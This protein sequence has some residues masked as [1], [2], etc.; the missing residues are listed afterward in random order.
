M[1]AVNMILLVVAGIL[2]FGF[3]AEFIFKKFGI[4]DLLL[5][6]ILGFIIGPHGFGY[7]S[8]EQ[9]ESA[10][11]VF[12]T[13]ALLFLLFDG[14]FNIDL[15]SFMRGLSKSLGI[16][17][18]NFVVSALGI[19]IVVFIAGK[20]LWDFTFMQALLTGLTLGGISSAFVIPL[21]K[22]LPLKSDTVSILT[23][24]SAITDVLCIVGAITA[25]EIIKVDSFQMQVMLSTIAS[26]FAVAGLIGIVA[27]VVWIFLVVNVLKEHKSYMVT[28]A[29]VILVYIIAEFLHGNGAIATLFLGLML[30]N[31]KQLTE[32]F[33]RI[34]SHDQQKAKQPIGV[35][36]T[37]HY[38]ELFYM[39]IS[40]FLKTFFFV[41]IGILFR[42]NN[43]Y[44]LIL[45][46][47]IVALLL[48]SR[49]ASSFLTK[50]FP[51]YDRRIVN[52]LFAR[53]LAAA[54]IT[55]MIVLNEVPNATVI[56]GIVYVVIGLSILFSSIRVLMIHRS[57][58]VAKTAS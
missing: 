48:G 26:I 57:A 7:V 58:G 43:P 3:I 6:I 21:I 10:A 28:I 51:D 40:F 34:V 15:S 25:I 36:V 29:Y 47:A 4:P 20:F 42:I 30:R 23:L 38:E 41:Y 31:S 1:V 18:V 24:E 37:T 44:E 14:A 50:E 39:Q 55:Q 46:I 8:P 11:P 33:Q 22:Q 32:L 54:A 13:F 27:G 16:T 12:T 35:A 56:A 5:L 53:G 17:M 52:A 2:F 45:G 49:Q 9:L 19:T